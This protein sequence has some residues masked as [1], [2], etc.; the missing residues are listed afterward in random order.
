M[1]ELGLTLKEKVM[2]EVIVYSTPTCPWCAKAKQFLDNHNVPYRAVDVTADETALEEMQKI[3]G[4]MGVPV[5]R[6]GE[7]VVVGF[8]LP[9][10]QELVAG[11]EKG[12]PQ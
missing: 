5:I 8:D 2:A 3:S 11:R 12:G 10:L 1:P 9:K 4:Q 7:T 6:A